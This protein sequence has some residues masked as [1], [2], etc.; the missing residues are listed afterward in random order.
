[1]FNNKNFLLLF[2]LLFL[3]SCAENLSKKKINLNKKYYSSLGFTLIYNESL[4]EN[5]TVNKKLNNEFSIFLHKTLKKNTKVKIINPVN[6]KVVETK[7]SKN[8]NYPNLF[9]SVIS[10][11]IASALELDPKNPY[12]EI[13][14]VKS[15]ET[16]IAKEGNIFDEEKNVADKAPVND[17]QMDDLTKDKIKKL[18]K[19]QQN[20][21]FILLIS[22]FYYEDSALNLKND[23]I[24]KT[25]INTFVIKKVNNTKYRLLAGPFK[26]FSAL[27][28]TYISLNN[29][30]FEKLDILTD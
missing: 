26:N 10:T 27:K 3:C 21:K 6:S 29:L 16:F 13:I 7:V 25:G 11:K 2:L 5:K 28:S 20:K 18:T 30:G 23:L 19:T 12:V 8:A 14:E 1:M 24:K 17:V 4:F 9:N 22:D 15:N